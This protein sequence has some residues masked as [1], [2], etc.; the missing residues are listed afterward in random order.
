MNVSKGIIV[1]IFYDERSEKITFL[2]TSNHELTNKQKIFHIKDM[3]FP[4]IEFY[5]KEHL[6]KVNSRLYYYY[7][8]ILL[9]I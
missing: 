8:N 1:S 7:K 9:F 2:I 6:F 3:H 4:W 5:K